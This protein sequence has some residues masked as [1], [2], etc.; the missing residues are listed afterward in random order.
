MIGL[1]LWAIVAAIGAALWLVGFALFTAVAGSVLGAI[2]LTLSALGIPLDVALAVTVFGIAG[3]VLL[4]T[5]G[6]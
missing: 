6:E 4:L 1:A 5:R 2:T 3:M